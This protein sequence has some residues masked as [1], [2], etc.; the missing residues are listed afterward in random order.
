MARDNKSRFGHPEGMRRFVPLVILL[1]VVIAIWMSGVTDQLSWANLARYQS[2]LLDWVARNGALAAGLYVV[3]YAVAVAVSLPQAAILTLTGGLLF[4]ALLGGALAV[5]GATAGA[6]GLYLVARS[7]IGDSLAARGGPFLRKLRDGLQRDGFLYLLSIRLI[8]VFPFWLV[9]LG[10]A[11]GGIRLVPYAA[12]TLIGIAPATFILASIGS[13]ISTILA[14][15]GTPDIS[16]LLS[17]PVL[18]PLVAL[19]LLSL[20]PVVWRQWRKSDG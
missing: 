5:I 8:P 9:N 11:L 3:T 6:V 10:A 16:V 17:F 19:A 12:A 20:L 7:A 4:G 15:G 2:G 14:S 13:G 1:A 18:G